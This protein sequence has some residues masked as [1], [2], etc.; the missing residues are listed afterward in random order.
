VPEIREIPAGSTN[1]AVPALQSLRPHLDAT[2]TINTID[3]LLRPAGYR[4]V[5]VFDDGQDPAAQ[6]VAGFRVTYALVRG[7]HL[8]IDEM[9]TMPA[10]QGR[11]YA[12]RL[13]DWLKQ[14]GVRAGCAEIHLDSAVGPDRAAA[15]RLYHRHHL[16]ISAHHFHCEL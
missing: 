11:G 4:L 10:A 9:A 12:G 3:E 8:V 16:R 15:H 14:E 6:A 2:R 5:G 13:M 1:L 7:L